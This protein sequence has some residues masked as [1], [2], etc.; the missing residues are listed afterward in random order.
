MIGSLILYTLLTCTAKPGNEVSSAGQIER[1]PHGGAEKEY[2]VLVEG[3]EETEIPIV[4]K[5]EP[6][7][8]SEKEAQDIF[9]TI[10]DQMEQ[11]IQGENPSLLEVSTDLKLPTR[12]E[13]LGIKLRW[14]S[15]EPEYLDNAGEILKAVEAEKEVVLAVWCSDG[16]HQAE[17]EIP[18]RLIPPNRTEQQIRLEGLQKEIMILEEQQRTQGQ[19]TLPSEYEGRALR[20]R[21]EEHNQYHV[22]P[23][24]GVVLAL[25]L[26][27]RQRSEQKEREKQ[28]EQELLLDYAELVSK[29]M[30]LIGAGMTIRNAFERI[31]RDYEDACSSKKRKTRAA[32]E[33]LKQTCFQMANGTS[34][35]L[36]Y[37]E[38]GRRCRLQPYLKLSSL[39]EQNQKT[40]T[41]NLRTIL[42]TEMEDA[43]EMRK[44]LA[45][46]MG[47]EA[48]TKLLVPLF[49]ILAI[50]M[51]MIMVPAMLT[52][53]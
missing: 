46:R 49:M 33:E 18:I 36:A 7:A 53:G 37:R 28:R 42:Q 16:I 8:Y 29:L 4:V 22:I 50:V 43:F 10:M 15:S 39:L 47:E 21:S 24:L 3:L 6:R 31:V 41:K 51:V 2:E 23:L 30:V 17:F 40:G 26:A 13:E 38:F 11:R 52:M 48:G 5:V 34:E 14:H 35:G 19:L 45:R 20:Y 1:A 12:M 9:Y 25:L 44:N 32:Y 27:A